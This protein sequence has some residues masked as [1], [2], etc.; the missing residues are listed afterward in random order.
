MEKLCTD[1]YPAVNIVTANF[2]ATA[3]LPYAGRIDIVIY[4]H[5]KK[6]YPV[7]NG[8]SKW[9]PSGDVLEIA[10]ALGELKHTGLRHISGSRYETIAD[11]FFSVFFFT[12]VFVSCRGRLER[13]ATFLPLVRL[14][15]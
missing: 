10:G 6:I 5:N 9:K 14:N 3:Y 13:S 15:N 7:R 8:F 12:A 1:G 2:K 4:Q 11:G